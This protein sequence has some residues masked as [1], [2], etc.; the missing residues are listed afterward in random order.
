MPTP[1]TMIARMKTS[2]ND[3][4]DG[5]PVAFSHAHVRVASIHRTSAAAA[6]ILTWRIRPPV[7]PTERTAAIAAPTAEIVQ[8]RLSHSWLGPDWSTT[9]RTMNGTLRTTATASVRTEGDGLVRR[10]PDHGATRDAS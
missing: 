8:W 6:R 10:H 9:D 7:P 4:T 1:G 3:G 2:A 5:L